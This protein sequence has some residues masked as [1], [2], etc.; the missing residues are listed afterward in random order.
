MK[1]PLLIVHTGKD[2]KPCIINFDNVLSVLP[3]NSSFEEEFGI[4]YNGSKAVIFGS[5]G[6]YFPV[7]E[8]VEQI[9]SIIMKR[10]GKAKGNCEIEFTVDSDP[11]L[12]SS[13]YFAF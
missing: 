1:M 3:Y 12:D 2:K 9:L 11:L 8:S 4:N 5:G 7:I 10:A 13:D 6:E